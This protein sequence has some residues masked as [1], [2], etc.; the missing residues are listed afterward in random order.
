MT[1]LAFE[2]TALCVNFATC[3]VSLLTLEVPHTGECV[4]DACFV[5][6]WLCAP[7]WLLEAWFLVHCTVFIGIW[8][9]SPSLRTNYYVSTNS[10]TSTVALCVKVLAAANTV[11]VCDY[12]ILLSLASASFCCMWGALA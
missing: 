2:R 12:T 9:L 10:V 6:S 11:N 4:E 3:V 7:S 5:F 1:Q 8:I